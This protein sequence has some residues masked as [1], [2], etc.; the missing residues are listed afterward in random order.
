MR[1][2]RAQSFNHHGPEMGGLEF[3]HRFRN[4]GPLLKLR[5]DVLFRL[6]LFVLLFISSRLDSGNPLSMLPSRRTTSS[7]SSHRLSRGSTSAGWS[8]DIESLDDPLREPEL[9]FSADCHNTYA[10][11][12]TKPGGV[13]SGRTVSAS[14]VQSS[15]AHPPSHTACQRLQRTHDDLFQL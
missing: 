9:R 4:S 6:V 7:S 3:K 12:S 1:H 11:S 2:L 5:H 14:S 8:S 15:Q 13:G 10:A